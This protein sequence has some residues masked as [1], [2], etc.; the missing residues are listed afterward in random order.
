[1]RIRTVLLE[2]EAH[3]HP[4]QP[5]SEVHGKSE[6]KHYGDGTCRVKIS[7]R[8]IPLPDGSQIDPWRDG[9]WLDGAI[10]CARQSSKS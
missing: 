1:M 5:D 8:D 10:N 4:I 6:W 9:S 3:F 7:S 2:F